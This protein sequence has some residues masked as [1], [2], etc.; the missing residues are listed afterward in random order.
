MDSIWNFWNPILY[1]YPEEGK[2]LGWWT[3]Q[4]QLQNVWHQ[5]T[6]IGL[7]M[8]AFYHTKYVI[9]RQ[10]IRKHKKEATETED[11]DL[12]LDEVSVEESD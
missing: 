6:L 9:K 7:Y 1:K 2:V 11:D 10:H 5:V 3:S 12:G 4:C 8:H